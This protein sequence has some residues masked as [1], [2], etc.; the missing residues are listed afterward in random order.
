MRDL[1]ALV[2]PVRD[3]VDERRVV[4]RRNLGGVGAGVWVVL[5]SHTTTYYT[6]LLHY[7]MP[8]HTIPVYTSILENYC[9][10]PHLVGPVQQRVARGVDD[11]ERHT[12]G[13]R[14]CAAG[15]TR[16]RVLRGWGRESCCG[17]GWCRG[18]VGVLWVSGMGLGVVG[19]SRVLRG[20]GRP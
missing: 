13:D 11:R 5:P 10:I 15:V 12:G 9:T 2:V 4:H 8:Y 14:L 1:L 7:A 17:Y 19:V 18:V 16:S 20:W 3:R 6:I